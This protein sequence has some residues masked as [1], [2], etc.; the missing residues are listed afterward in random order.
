MTI[1]KD[2]DALEFSVTDEGL[3]EVAKEKDAPEIVVQDDT[4]EADR[5][6]GPS[7]PIEDPTDEELQSY[8]KSVQQRIK[9]LSR[10]RH[11]ARRDKEAIER[12]AQ[13]MQRALKALYE[14]NQQLKA[15]THR[16]HTALLTS[17][18]QAAKLE[19]EQA[20]KEYRDAYEAG[21]ADK[22]LAAQEKLI[23]A[24][25][26]LDRVTNVKVPPLQEAGKPVQQT[27]PVSK[28]AA[29]PDPKYLAWREKNSWFGGE[30]AED[31]EMTALALATHNN[32]V[33]SGV[34]PKSDEYYA[35]INARMQSVFP[36]RFGGQTKQPASPAAVTPVSRTPP[37]KKITLTKTQ[38]DLA[39]RLGITPAQYAQEVLKISQK[40]A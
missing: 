23:S 33:R 35:R 20:Q 34:D 3:K 28:P 29:D 2:D 14:E 4:P 26:K 21:D 15:T 19:H 1:E 8:S 9:E 39:K 12:Q 18:Q 40:E 16:G 36:H 17:A 24:K 38:L 6:R 27:Q 7:A 5:G 10:A 13:E 32:L 30:T 22:V 25:L 11:D 31:A 37:V